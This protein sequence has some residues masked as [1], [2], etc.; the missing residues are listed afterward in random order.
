M[1]AGTPA[2]PTATA[3]MQ[4]TRTVM[5]PAPGTRPHLLQQHGVVALK[6]LEDVVVAA[7]L[8]QPV[9]GGIAVAAC[10]TGCL[11]QGAVCSAARRAH[12]QHNSS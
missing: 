11:E 3:H 12:V 8:A 9:D 1:H 10:D 5:V 2:H 7:Q 4:H 6:R